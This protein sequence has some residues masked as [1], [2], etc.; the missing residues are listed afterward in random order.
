MHSEDI[1]S[2]EAVRTGL[3]NAPSE[4][5]LAGWDV[6]TEVPSEAGTQQT[7]LQDRVHELEAEVE[8][9]KLALMQQSISGASTSNTPSTPNNEN[10]NDS[11]TEYDTAH[12]AGAASLADDW[13]L[14]EDAAAIAED[15]S[16]PS[17][18]APTEPQ[19]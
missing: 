6:L 10:D 16:E 3:L 19:V 12:E 4:G 5:S 2:D 7:F 9:L 13:L 8:R 17:A 1:G 15:S 14:T 11:E 18:S